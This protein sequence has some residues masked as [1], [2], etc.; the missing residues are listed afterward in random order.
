MQFFFFCPHCKLQQSRIHSFILLSNL[1]RLDNKLRLAC[2]YVFMMKTTLDPTLHN[3]N[4]IVKL[5]LTSSIQYRI[6]SYEIYGVS[7]S[8]LVMLLLRGIFIRMKHVWFVSSSD[9]STH[10]L[11][12]RLTRLNIVSHLLYNIIALIEH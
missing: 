4:K 12:F 11:S 2:L 6:S 8:L 3:E 9:I 7:V 10:L 5:L 1:L